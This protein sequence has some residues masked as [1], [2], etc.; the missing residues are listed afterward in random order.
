MT[1]RDINQYIEHLCGEVALDKLRTN[2][3]PLLQKIYGQHFEKDQVQS[4]ISDAASFASNAEEQLFYEFVQNAYDANAKSLYFFANEKY[5]VV[6]NNGKPFYT[7]FDIF[8]E[9]GMRPRDGQLYSF[10][11]KG[12]SSKWNDSNTLGKY[13]QGSKL[14]YTLLTDVSEGRGNEDL[15]IDAIYNN[16]KGP[17]LISWSNSTQLAN[18]LLKQPEWI[19]AKGDDYENNILFVKILMSYY[20]ITPR[21]DEKLFSTQEALDAI[22]AFDTLVDPRRNLHFLNKGGTALIIPLGKGK[23]ERITS[24]ENLERVKT[25]LGGFASITK[26][27]ERNDGKAVEHIYIMGEEI[28]QHAVRSVFVEFNVEENPFYYHFAFNPVFA[29]NGFVNLFKGLPV[30]EAK[31]GLGFIIDSQKFDV[32]SSRQRIND[33]GKTQEQ[34]KKAFSELVVK[35]KDLK[36]TDSKKFDY[37]YKS[38][39]ATRIPNGEDFKYIRDSFETVFKPFFEENVLTSTG[40]YENKENVR[41]YSDAQQIPLDTIGIT[42][43]QWINEDSKK[44]LLHHGVNI[45]TINLSTIFADANEIKLQTWIKSLSYNEYVKFHSL[46]DAHKTEIG[47]CD[48]KLFKTNKNNLYSYSELR[49]EINVYYSIEDNMSF[50]ECEHVICPF[51]NI[52]LNVFLSILFSKIKKNIDSF[53]A[54]DFSKDDAANLLAW[55]STKDDNYDN[56]IR[57]EILLL[58]NM[59]DEYCSFDNLFIERPENTILFDNYCVKGHIPQTVVSGNWLLSPKREQKL[60][61]QWIVNH[62]QKLQKD[63]EWGENT[64]RYISDVKTVYRAVDDIPTSNEPRLTLNLDVDGKPITDLRVIVNKVSELTE[65]EYYYLDEKIAHL[66]LMPYE[67]HQE[68]Q[69]APFHIETVKPSDIVKDELLADKELLRIFIKITSGYLNSYRTQ[70][71][72]SKYLITKTSS[73]YNYIDSV[74]QDLQDELLSANFYH[75]PTYV[76]ELL[77]AESSKYKFVDNM[78]IKAIEKIENPI[79][80]LPFVKQ[81]NKN[82]VGTFFDNLKPIFIDSKITKEDLRWQVIEFAVHESTDNK[83]YIANVLKLIKHND[84][85]LPEDIV[86]QYISINNNQYSV[87]ELDNNYKVDNQAIDSFLNC[88]PS[89]N[90]VDFFKKYFYKDKEEEISTEEL[91]QQLHKTYLTIE[92]LRFCIDYSIAN[93]KDYNELEI[94]ENESVTEAL[95]MILKNKFS[96]FDKF[97]KMPGVNYETQ[98]CAPKEILRE[99]ELLPSEIQIWIEK[100]PSIKELFARLKT[101]SNPYIAVRKALLNNNHSNDVSIFADEEKQKEIDATIDWAI[102]KNL[103]YVCDSDRYKTMM[104]IIENLP[105][106]YSVMPFLRYTGNIEI[107]TTKPTFILERCQDDFAFLSVSS[108]LKERLQQSKKLAK[109]IESKVVYVYGKS[110]LLY[111]HGYKDK[112]I[113]EIQESVDMKKFP[114]HS[115]PV[116]DKWK[117]TPES[118]GIT[119]HTSETPIIMNFNITSGNESIFADKMYDSEFGYELNKCIVIQQPNKE[120]LSL[121]KTIAKHIASMGFFKEPFIALQALYVDEWELSQQKTKGKGGKG[122]G[123]SNIDLSKSTLTEKQAQKALDKISNETADNL[124][125]VND[126]TKQMDRNT[127]DKLNKVADPIKNILDVLEKEDI[128]LIAEN[129]DKVMQALNDLA[130]AEKEEKESKVRPIIGFIG[131]LIYGHYLENQHKEYD[132]AA[133]RGVGEYDFEVKT[134]NMYVDVKTTLYSLK[135]GTAPFYLHRSQDIFMQKHPKSKYH[136]I[137]ISLI[138]LNLKKS[139]EKLRDIYGTDVNPLGNPKLRKECEKIAKEYWRSAKIEEF[140]ALSLKYEIRSV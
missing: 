120:N 31:L 63:E 103:I 69:E 7:D 35:L 40:S 12:K 106:D 29:R 114:E 45:D 90:E 8:E 126:L 53:R 121:M 81:A 39:L 42:K 78:L 70:E 30:I 55:I 99:N 32:D 48:C 38:L 41:T 17:Y 98:A 130:D 21:V 109:F 50:G 68:L 2:K 24:K 61:W 52:E 16:Y 65:K 76:Q 44:D 54:T 91:Y 46:A 96:G 140:D 111:N 18:L 123:K 125:K 119:I 94:A 58:P 117:T 102:E 112:S 137:R 51:S 129:K 92:Q 75:I 73:G 88:L 93:N 28:E 118:K 36:Q 84:N 89:Q 86:K 136:I 1:I 135:D 132:H 97:F 79:K 105:S 122:N 138:D 59:H 64:H 56:R 49:T 3:E 43:Y 19:P 25:R 57:K 23:Y 26:D 134:D 71:K 128:Q 4:V 27:Q 116:Y 9:N 131:E 37:I 74:S 85:N 77:N 47:V 62:W 115:D 100:N 87:Y 34:L 20:P 72:D 10:L 107:E 67:Y 66:N 22:E 5:L 133:L 108:Q 104:G 83:N 124:D 113:W 14:L 127:L 80:L 6:L 13:G 15:L 60:C 101:D 11:A 33:K 139:Y 110:K 95:N 82:V